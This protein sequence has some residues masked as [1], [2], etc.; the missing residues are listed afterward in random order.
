MK[1]ITFD[2]VTGT[3]LALPREIDIPPYRWEHGSTGGCSGCAFR[4][5]LDIRCS[6]IPCQF[7]QGYIAVLEKK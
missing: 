4:K 2:P 1:T 5:R 7:H 6:R 3:S